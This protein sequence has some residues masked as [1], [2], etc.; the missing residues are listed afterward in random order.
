MK[1]L[2]IVRHAKSSWL[3]QGIKDIDRPLKERGIKDSHL[4]SKFL[5][6]EI[7]KPDVFVSSS[8]N[9][10]LH[11][12]IIFCENFKYP[13][14]NLQIKRQLYNFSDGYLVKTVN[15]LDDNFSSAIIFS[16]DHGINS[17]VNNF[18]DKP[19]AH[20][21]T[22]GIIGIEFKDKH[23]KNLKKGRTILVDFPKNHR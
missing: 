21:P 15:A 23:W 13:L 17:F 2:Y 10:A 3:Y 11:T 4:F 14:S 1:T 19:I 22:C 6:Q 8:A 7:A 9:R 5:S 18:G 12:A 16:H 20:V